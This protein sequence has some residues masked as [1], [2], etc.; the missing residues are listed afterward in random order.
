MSIRV[1]DPYPKSN[2][3]EVTNFTYCGALSL[4]RK[5]KGVA[6]RKNRK[7]IAI[8][9]KDYEVA[10]CVDN[11]RVKLLIQSGFITDGTSVPSWL[12]WLASVFGITRW[13]SG[14][15]ASVIHDYLYVAWQFVEN[16]SRKPNK[17]DKKFADTVFYAGLIA[18]RVP[19]WKARIMYRASRCCGWRT[20]KEEN[21]NSWCRKST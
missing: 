11:S 10:Y 3:S 13:G 19:Q 18:A 14:V 20:Y 4:K 7:A 1:V 2:W 17:R 5:S 8:I 6:T 21:P 16:A 15:E 9:D 12:G